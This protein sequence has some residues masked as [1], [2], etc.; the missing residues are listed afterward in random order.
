M[1]EW[2]GGQEEH[3]QGKPR[4]GLGS[5]S[6]IRCD[7]VQIKEGQSFE[8]EVLMQ[9]VKSSERS[10]WRMNSDEMGAARGNSHLS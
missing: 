4:S 2:C 5:R 1:G 3:K 9:S 6:R 7:V 10:E 8:K